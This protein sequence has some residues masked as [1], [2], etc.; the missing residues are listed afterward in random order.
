[1]L[2]RLYILYCIKL[3]EV[4]IDVAYDYIYII[5]SKKKNMTIYEH[6]SNLIWCL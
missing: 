5:Q 4:G 3:K 6:W 1:M 2:K